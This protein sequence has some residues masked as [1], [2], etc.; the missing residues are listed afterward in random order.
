MFYLKRKIKDMGRNAVS[1]IGLLIMLAAMGLAVFFAIPYVKGIPQKVMDMIGW[2][3]K[4][5]E[6]T[7]ETPE[8]QVPPENLPGNA[9]APGQ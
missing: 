5:D 9:Q 7:S 8:G 2:G 6:E 1:M 3:E 4:S